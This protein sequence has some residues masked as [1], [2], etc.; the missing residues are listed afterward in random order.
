MS[1]LSLCGRSP[2]PFRS[3]FVGGCGCERVLA[4]TPSGGAAKINLAVGVGSNADTVA[5]LTP[6]CSTS[7]SFAAMNSFTIKHKQICAPALWPA[8]VIFC[9]S[10]PSFLT[11]KK[12]HSTAN[13]ISSI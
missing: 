10:P 6:L 5:L 1:S 3:S 8:R 4:A 2:D 7:N 13:L 9:G 11:F 12:V